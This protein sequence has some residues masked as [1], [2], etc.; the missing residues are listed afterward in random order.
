MISTISALP[1]TATL[2]D[3]QRIRLC[4][5][6][7][8]SAQRAETKVRFMAA[9]F[10]II[11][12][13]HNQNVTKTLGY[14]DD[15]QACFL[16]DLND[17]NFPERLLLFRSMQQPRCLLTLKDDEGENQ[18]QVTRKEDEDENQVFSEHSKEL[19]S[20]FFIHIIGLLFS[21]WVAMSRVF[22][23][24]KNQPQRQALMIESM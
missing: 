17:Q 20:F 19:V 2:N 13:S 15:L 16:C 9:I 22:D 14:N 21:F 23:S 10:D 18:L 6:A 1:D 8:W 12:L 24:K 4:L 7:H 5:Q 11:L 3:E